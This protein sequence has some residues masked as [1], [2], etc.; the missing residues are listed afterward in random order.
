VEF[1]VYQLSAEVVF[2][3]LNLGINDNRAVSIAALELPTNAMGR[4]TTAAYR[5]A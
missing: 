3:L 4:D 5:N 1:L 2:I